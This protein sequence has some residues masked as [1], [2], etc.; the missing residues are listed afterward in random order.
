MPPAATS[1]IV[2]DTN[3]VLDWLVFR[4]TS[5]A[6]LGEAIGEER[7]QWVA[8]PWMRAEL[9]HVLNRGVADRWRPD[10]DAIALAWQQWA[11]LVPEPQPM[12]PSMRLHCS[13]PL[14]QPFIDLAL[15]VGAHW[16]LSKDKALLKLARRACARQLQIGTPRWWSERHAARD[17]QPS[18]TPTT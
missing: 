8:S 11:R 6:A 10:R 17:L 13:D 4:D 12:P 3:V 18:T 7:L 5:C 9:E 14:D 1:L 15:H 16:L 2:L